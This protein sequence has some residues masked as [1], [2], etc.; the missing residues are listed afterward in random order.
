MSPIVVE[1][2]MISPTHIE[3]DQ[4]VHVSDAAVQVEIRPRTAASREALMGLLQRMAAFPSANRSKEDI[5]RQIQ[6]E[7]DSWESRR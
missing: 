2:R 6:E 5:D 3:L 7:R 4:P 1:G